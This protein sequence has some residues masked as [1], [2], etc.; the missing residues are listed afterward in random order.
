[1]K[2][3]DEQLSRILSA[4]AAG[5]LGMVNLGWP[6]YDHSVCIEQAAHASAAAMPE[7]DSRFESERT[8]AWDHRLYADINEGEPESVLHWLE[9]R[10][11]A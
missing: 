5:E 10:G 8:H 4:S 11:W 9:G 2:Y 6:G 7:E 3:T 1:M